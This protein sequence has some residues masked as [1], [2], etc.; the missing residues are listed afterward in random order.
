[1]QNPL[2]KMKKAAPVIL[3]LVFLAFFIPYTI[4]NRLCITY[5]WNKTLFPPEFPSPSFSW[6][7][8]SGFNGLYEVS[9]CS[10]SKLFSFDTL[11]GNESWSS[12]E[13]QWED[14]KQYSEELRFSVKRKGKPGKA[15]IVFWFSPDSVAAPILYRQMPIPFVVAEKKLDSMNY[16]L[17]NVGSP[18]PPHTAMK[19][20]SVCGNCHS[21]TRD[22]RT[23]GLDLDAGRRDKGGFFIAPVKD[24]I[25]FNIENYMSWTRIEKRKTFGLFSKISPDG[26]YIVTTVKDRVMN[27]NYPDNPETNA[28]SQVFFP[29]NGHLAVYDRKT[30]QLKELPG[31]DLEEYV[32]SNATWTPDGEYIV[33]CR[34]KSFPVKYDTS[35]VDIRSRLLIDEKRSINIS[36]K[37]Y[38]EEFIKRNKSFTYDICIIPF[39]HGS[40]GVAKPV[41]GASENGMSNYFPA[42]SPDG[43]WIVFCKSENFM[44]L[45]PDSRLY[46]VPVKGGRA[47]KL[48][49]NLPLMNSW[50]AWSP[51][52]KWIVFVSKGMSIYTDMFISHIDENGSASPPVLLEKAR[53]YQRVANYPEFINTKPG[54]GFDMKYDYVEMAHIE[55]ALEKGDIKEAESLYKRFKYQDPLLLKEDYYIL[56]QFLKRMGLDAEIDSLREKKISP[57]IN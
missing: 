41:K 24:T 29:V 30:R 38:T 6:T 40:G 4:N 37:D 2:N 3:L 47:K 20:F 27:I 28:F 45:Q 9:L 52:S 12:T 25:N 26:R 17:I 13:A 15:T 50:H 14:L 21:F 1:M 34:A 54:Y 8:K 16:M 56:Y 42:V 10:K 7:D 55:R 48:S 23:I 43:K 51:N 33:F 39:N 18:K 36:E 5:P 22:G 44:L 49:C 35:G 19:G 46:I 32:Q 57:V 31:A 11:T 53:R